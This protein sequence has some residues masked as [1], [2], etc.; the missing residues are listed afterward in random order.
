[1]T[2]NP[3]FSHDDVK[4]AYQQGEETVIALVDGLVALIQHLEARVQ[5]LEDQ[6]AKSSRNSGK[7]PSSDGYQ[8]PRP[9]SLRQPSGRS[10]GG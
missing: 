2:S 1:M 5:A 4:A 9:R 8:K 3:L 6:L 10:S 7:P